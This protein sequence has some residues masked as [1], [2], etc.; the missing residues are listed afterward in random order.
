M[1][2]QVTCITGGGRGYLYTPSIFSRHLH[3]HVLSEEEER[4]CVALRDSN[5]AGGCGDLSARAHQCT[6]RVTFRSNHLDQSFLSP[7]PVRNSHVI[8]FGEEIAKLAG[9]PAG[10]CDPFDGFGAVDVE[11]GT[12]GVD[13]TPGVWH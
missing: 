2:S 10:S 13:V 7:P 9:Q 3:S 1:L 4:V 5:C 11:E 6:A 12:Q 8:V